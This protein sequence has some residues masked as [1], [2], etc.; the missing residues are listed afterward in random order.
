VWLLCLDGPSLIYRHTVLSRPELVGLDAIS[1]LVISR[2]LGDRPQKRAP[3][4]V[5][6]LWPDFSATV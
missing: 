6:R 3:T 4:E 2:I 1:S 5:G